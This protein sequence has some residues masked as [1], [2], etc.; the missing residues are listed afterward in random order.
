[1]SNSPKPPVYTVAPTLPYC[2]NGTSSTSCIKYPPE[3][4][5]PPKPYPVKRLPEPC[6]AVPFEP[7]NACALSSQLDP[8]LPAYHPN[9]DCQH[10]TLE[11]GFWLIVAAACM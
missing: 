10:V 1:M 9:A 2:L 8:A 4:V 7:P 5:T 11:L 3:K 6:A